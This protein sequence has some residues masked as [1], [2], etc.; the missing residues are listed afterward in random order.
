[1][2]AAGSSLPAEVSRVTVR[3]PTFWAERPAV[4]FAQAEAQFLAGIS[5][6]MTKFYHVISQLDQRY[7][8]ELEDVITSLPERDPYTTLRTELM[9]QLSPSREQ[10]IRQ[11]L[12]LEMGDRKPPQF[13]RHLR[14]LAPDAPDDFL[15]SI[16][17]SRLPPNMQ[18]I[19]AGQHEGSLD[20]T[21]RS[22]DRI[23]EVASQPGLASVGPPPDSTSLLR[24]IEDLSRQV[25]ALN[26][27]QDLFRN[28]S[29]DPHLTSRDPCSSTR[30][31]R[32]G[33]RNRRPVSRSPSRD[34]AAATL[35]W[36]H[37][38]FG[39]RAQKCIPPCSYRQQRK[40]TQQIS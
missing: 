18:A 25:A 11:F 2:E 37:H 28:C 22:T 19:L 24:G 20:A 34:D 40:P 21:A 36:Y 35:C 33:S 30:D 8:T 5:S 38:R 32:P 29:R 13:L 6:E 1:M 39:V 12:A 4:W 16:W 23:S 14:S 9:R 3:L 27:E 17:S 15:R 31:P 26:A 10:C 7:A